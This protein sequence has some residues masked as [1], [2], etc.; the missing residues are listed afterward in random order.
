MIYLTS[1]AVT[2]Q[3]DNLTI[4]INKAL[5]TETITLSGANGG[6][7][8]VITGAATAGARFLYTGLR[9]RGIITITPSGAI[10]AAVNNTSL[11]I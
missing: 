10:D 3:T 9:S 1:S 2:I 5:T 4:Q 7:F 11:G 8:A 6:T